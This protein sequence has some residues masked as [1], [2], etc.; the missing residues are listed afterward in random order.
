MHRHYFPPCPVSGSIEPPVPFGHMA[1]RG[2]VPNKCGSCE[3]L[4][5]GE[6]LRNLETTGRFLHLD[7]GPCGIEGPTNGVLVIGTD[8]EV[9]RKCV[10]C[11]FLAHDQVHGFHCQKDADK[12]GGFHRSLD[13]GDW[14]P[15]FFYLELPSPKLTTTALSMSVHQND[16]L[17]F[18]KEYRRINP[19]LSIREA[20]ED[21][22]NLRLAREKFGYGDSI[23]SGET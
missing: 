7:H 5:E 22:V 1:T 8:L 19:G 14:S 16:L 4:F 15:P 17:A 11:K 20:K 6:C 21:F 10:T 13:W 2:A 3:L 23:G 12:W 9:P 18:I